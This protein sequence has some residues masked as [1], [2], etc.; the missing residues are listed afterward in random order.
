MNFVEKYSCIYLWISASILTA[1]SPVVPSSFLGAEEI[2]DLLSSPLLRGKLKWNCRTMDTNELLRNSHVKHCITLS[3]W[4]LQFPSN[5]VVFEKL[6]KCLLDQKLRN[7]LKL[8][9]NYLGQT[10]TSR[11]LLP[12]PRRREENPIQV[13]TEPTNP[14]QHKLGGKNLTGSKQTTNQT[15]ATERNR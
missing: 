7:I 12:T 4:S 15:R 2:S 6:S 9:S 10:R 1:F 11:V 5:P 14:N 13:P 8:N 3:M